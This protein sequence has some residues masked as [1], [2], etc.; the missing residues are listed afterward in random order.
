MPLIY[1]GPPD[2]VEELKAVFRSGLPQDVASV[3]RDDEDVE[4]FAEIMAMAEGA[5]SGWIRQSQI[6]TATG[7][8]LE[9][10][11]HDQGLRK[12]FGETD[13]HFRARLRLPPT[14]GTRD[15]IFGA[16]SELL[17]LSE[18]QVIVVELPRDAAYAG[19]SFCAGRGVRMGERRRQMVI[20]LIPA[21]V[22]GLKS[23]TDVLRTKVSAGKDY[24]VQEY[25]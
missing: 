5:L 13:Q 23:A 14:A 20:V 11:G 15:A 10:H 9:E 18:D 1:T 7:M 24:L 25:S 4:A 12:Q 19:R 8:W 21:S 22:G 3:A 16:I 17:G 2:V 6:R